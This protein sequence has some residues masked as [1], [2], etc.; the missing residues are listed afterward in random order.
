MAEGELDR[1]DCSRLQAEFDLATGLVN[2][3]LGRVGFIDSSCAKLVSDQAQQRRTDGYR[4]RVFA[5]PQVTKTLEILASAGLTSARELLLDLK[6][7]RFAL[8]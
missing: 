3:D 2:L 6:M 1:F 5:S 4:M 8:A 7:L